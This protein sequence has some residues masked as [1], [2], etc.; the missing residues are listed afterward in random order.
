MFHSV[1]L[2]AGWE[3][4]VSDLAARGALGGFYLAGGTALA[5]QVGHRRSVDLDLFCPTD[6]DVEVLQTTLTG[7]VGLHVRQAARGTLHLEL[8]HV[9]VSFLHYPYPLLFPLLR[10]DRLALADERDVACMKVGAIASRGS[11][12]DFIDL[13]IS[14]RTH[15]LQ[16]ILAWFKTKYAGGGYSMVHVFKAL[17]YFKDAEPQPMPDM[18]VPLDWAEVKAFFTR[19]VP[20]LL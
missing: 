16:D 4:A 5:L 11:R 8:R 2:P 13:Y 12:R 15:G 9:L 3:L 18:L 14:A 10:F 17:T 19:E 1:V 6:F 20:R 7:L